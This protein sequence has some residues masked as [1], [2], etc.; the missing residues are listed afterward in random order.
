MS[1]CGCGCGCGCG[2]AGPDG[3]IGPRG[4]QGPAGPSVVDW[5][6]T[7]PSGPVGSSGSNGPNGPNGP[8]GPTGA[9][10]GSDGQ[11]ETLISYF[12]PY[13]ADSTP[14]LPWTVAFTRGF[15]A[16]QDQPYFEDMRIEASSIV[17]WIQSEVW[18]DADTIWFGGQVQIVFPT[19]PETEAGQPYWLRIPRPRQFGTITADFP[20]P[21]GNYIIRAVDEKGQSSRVWEGL[22]LA[23]LLDVDPSVPYAACLFCQTGSSTEKVLFGHLSPLRN[24]SAV[25]VNLRYQLAQP[26]RFP[27]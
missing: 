9:T 12:Q 16:P 19:V 10:G 3:P 17:E 14:T 23:Q 13:A 5:P 7:G 25:W 8:Q 24:G 4:F 11:L 1:S 18:V 20:L 2:G 26:V 27:V 21:V 15:F 6:I 22:C